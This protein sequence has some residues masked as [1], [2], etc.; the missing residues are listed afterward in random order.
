MYKESVQARITELENQNKTETDEYF[1]LQDALIQADDEI[2]NNNM[3][4]EDIIAQREELEAQKDDF[5][6]QQREAEEAKEEAEEA[7]RNAKRDMFR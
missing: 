7:D 6:R 1:G 2:M 5:M 3:W 4:K